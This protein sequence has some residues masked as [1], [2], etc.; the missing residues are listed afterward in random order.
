ERREAWRNKEVIKRLYHKWYR[1]VAEML[2]PGRTLELGG[3]S[4]NLKG[5]LPEAITSDIIFV[6]WLDAVMDA[7]ALPFRDETLDNLVLCDVLHHLSAPPLFFREAERVLKPGGRIFM[8]EPYVS[9]VSFF[10]YRFIHAEGMNVHVN[11][12]EGDG[13]RRG[14]DPFEGNQ[15]IPTLIFEKYRHKFEES[16]P[17][18]KI[19]RNERMDPLVYP[20]SGGFHNPSLCPPFLWNLLEYV[21]RLL[22]PLSEYVSFRLFVVA[23]KR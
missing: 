16:F 1:M 20:L 22:R 23:E 15:A 14:K 19:I 8:V 3:G 11:L 4:G 5:F 17:C 10:V 13:S 2:R 9:W 6:P 12:F 7:H 21:E 18:L